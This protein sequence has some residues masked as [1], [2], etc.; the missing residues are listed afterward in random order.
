[1]LNWGIVAANC[2]A[3]AAT[4][5]RPVLLPPVITG[6]VYGVGLLYDVDQIIR[7][8][9]VG[10]VL[11]I[12]NLVH[13]S[14]KVEWILPA[15][16]TIALSVISTALGH[17]YKY[18]LYIDVA[19]IVCS[20]L[21]AVALR[22]FKFQQTVAGVEFCVW[23]IM[24]GRPSRIPG[25]SSHMT[26]WGISVLALRLG[27]IACNR[28]QLFAGSQAVIAGTVLF[29]TWGM[30]LNGCGM[31]ITAIQD[32]GPVAYIFGNYALHYYPITRAATHPTTCFDVY[33]VTL[34]VSLVTIY[35]TTL[36]AIDI[37]DCTSTPSEI[38]TLGLPLTAA[39]IGWLLSSP[40]K[41]VT[42]PELSLNVHDNNFKKF[43]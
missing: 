10:V 17:T 2:L 25:Q 11:L 34:A 40:E 38:A 6:A 22:A 42:I 12:V 19:V 1:M 14:T 8:V 13:T 5:I 37:Y 36:N 33:E 27:A 35:T 9:A 28:T 7:G 20:V 41:M 21:W 30:S 26:W 31:L 29:G 32:L 3:V 15:I 4:W 23:A 43:Q 39:G 18:I 16:F 24:L